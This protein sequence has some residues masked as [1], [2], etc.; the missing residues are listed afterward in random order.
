M[1]H[2]FQLHEM[3]FISLKEILSYSN[4]QVNQNLKQILTFSNIWANKKAFRPPNP[5]LES[6]MWIQFCYS[7]NAF[8]LLIPSWNK[9]GWLVPG[10]VS[11]SK[12]CS[13]QSLGS[14][15]RISRPYHLDIKWKG[16]QIF[17]FFLASLPEMYLVLDN[18]Y[19]D[20]WILERY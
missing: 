11:A 6:G 13:L 17:F 8:A 3:K 7:A 14:Q 10:R 4:T 18:L 19:W 16:I 9:R 12:F 5:E 15:F 1:P 20:S 2:I